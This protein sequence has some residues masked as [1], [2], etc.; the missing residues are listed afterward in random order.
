MAL[1]FCYFD[2]EYIVSLLILHSSL[3]DLYH[4]RRLQMQ[5]MRLGFREQIFAHGACPV[6]LG[7]RKNSCSLWQNLAPNIKAFH[8]GGNLFL[9]MIKYTNIVEVD[10][11][12]LK[13]RNSL[14]IYPQCSVPCRRSM[15]AKW[16]NQRMKKNQTN[17]IF[18]NKFIHLDTIQMKCLVKFYATFKNPA[19]TKIS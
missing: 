1:D 19:M 2:F 8:K 10:Y 17:I 11:E 5:Q 9:W 16:E 13:V 12:L 15:T 3:T 6:S 4:M 18:L 7:A 14:I